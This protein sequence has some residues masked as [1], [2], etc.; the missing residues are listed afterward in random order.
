M[1]QSATKVTVKGR[2]VGGGLFEARQGATDKTAKFS[3]CVVLND[4]EDKKIDKIIQA[5]VKEKFPNKKPA[6]MQIWGVREGDD[7]DFEASFDQKFINPKS[8]KSPQ[9]LVKR[10]GVAHEVTQEDDILYPGCYVA[11]SVGAYAYPADKDKG[12]KAGA[13]LQVR[14]VMFMKDG[15]RLGDVVDADEEF[16][17]ID[18]SEEEDFDVF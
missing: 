14:A 13:S 8:S 18:D 4:G 3:A 1:A 7:E 11:V 9:T 6:G 17:E 15:E 12:I 2:F 5:A 16:G 10:E